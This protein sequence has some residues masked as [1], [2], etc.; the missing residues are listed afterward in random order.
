MAQQ[1]DRMLKLIQEVDEV[2]RQNNDSNRLMEGFRAKVFSDMSYL[3]QRV[4][5]LERAQDEEWRRRMRYRL[6]EGS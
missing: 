3:E 5:R 6:Q 2:Q 4:H 1:E